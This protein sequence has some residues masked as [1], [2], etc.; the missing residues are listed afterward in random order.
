MFSDALNTAGAGRPEGD[1]GTQTDAKKPAAAPLSSFD[2]K[3]PDAG[4]LAAKILAARISDSKFFADARS[5]ASRRRESDASGKGARDDRRNETNVSA[6]DT[7]AILADPIPQAGVSPSG[8]QGSGATVPGGV[9]PQPQSA[10]APALPSGNSTS[11]AAPPIAFGATIQTSSAAASAEGQ[12][13]VLANNVSAVASAWKK[14]QHEGAAHDETGDQ[15]G[16]SAQTG[17]HEAPAM[18]SP[19]TPASALL[20]APPPTPATPKAPLRALE[21]PPAPEPSTSPSQLKDLSFRIQQ[22][23]GS[24]VQLRVTQHSGELRLAVHAAN[25]DLS[26]GLRESLGDLTKK[27]ADGGFRAETWRPGVAASPAP[28]Q[29]NTSQNQDTNRNGSDARQQQGS[30]DQSSEQREQRQPR[31]RWAEDFEGGLLSATGSFTGVLT[32]A[33]HGI[34]N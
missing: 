23:D 17:A 14:N 6:P 34:V 9:A 10:A 7:S 16:A 5:L 12:R 32:G 11:N 25:A 21:V 13:M 8:A 30:G 3:L 26:Q 27:L 29:T 31:P 20:T 2:I 1:T 24:A 33:T 15:P 28:A 4:A 22:A 19:V 18:P